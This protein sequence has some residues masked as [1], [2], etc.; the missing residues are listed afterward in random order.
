MW[1]HNTGIL[2]IF[3]ETTIRL[4]SVQSQCYSSPMF[5]SSVCRS[6]SWSSLTEPSLKASS[7]HPSQSDMALPPAASRE[8]CHLNLRR[9]YWDPAAL[10]HTHLHDNRARKKG[11]KI[12]ANWDRHLFDPFIYLKTLAAGL[13]H[14]HIG[15]QCQR[16]QTW[17]WKW[18]DY[19]HWSIY[20]IAPG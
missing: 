5:G 2:L 20:M 7:H 10:H 13:S 9:G 1:R 12:Y 15:R 14:T 8:A 18:R 4:Q 19:W 6:Q 3:L 11:K 17:K 16:L